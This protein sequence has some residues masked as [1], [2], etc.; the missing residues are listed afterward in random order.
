MNY[1]GFSHVDVFMKR[2]KWPDLVI[3]RR[4]ALQQGYRIFR[5]GKPCNVCGV[6]SWRAVV[7]WACL[8]CKREEGNFMKL[9]GKRRPVV[10]YR[11][12]AE[13]SSE[14]PATR[15]EAIEEQIAFYYPWGDLTCEVPTHRAGTSIVYTVS[16]IKKCC[17]NDLA[18]AAYKEAQAAGEPT[19]AKEAREMG[20]AYYW[21]QAPM[22]YCGH[23]GKMLMNGKCWTC[24]QETLNTPR[25]VALLDGAVWYTP[26]PG[27]LCRKGHFAL[28]RVANGSCKQCEDEGAAVVREPL[29]Q[30]ICPDLIISRA[31]SIAAGF[32]VYRTGAACNRGHF[33]WRYNSTSGC[34]DCKAGG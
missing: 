22:P 19:S 21:Q 13:C 28:R 26:A 9:R 4:T 16:N 5:T 31:N 20:L 25:Q 27:D 29:L 1:E 33:G 2:K 32:K 15:A 24:R 7:N 18:A 6:S 3:A 34:L 12:G 8:N 17:A 11:T 30:D 23:S 10:N 14:Y